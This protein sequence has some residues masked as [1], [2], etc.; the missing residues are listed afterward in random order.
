[1]KTLLLSVSLFVGI[2]SSSEAGTATFP[3]KDPAFT[4]TYPDDWTVKVDSEGNLNFKA[5]ARSGP[6]F[7]IQKLDAKTEEEVTVFLQRIVKSLDLGDAKT[8]KVSEIKETTT[9]KGVKLRAITSANTAMGVEMIYS[10]T[11]FAP[12]KG[13]YFGLLNVGFAADLKAQEKEITEVLNSITPVSGED[14]E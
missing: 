7:L 8:A 5:G 4:V 10:D 1:M 3:E 14:A 9:P 13:V 6:S 12:K 2:L 11:A